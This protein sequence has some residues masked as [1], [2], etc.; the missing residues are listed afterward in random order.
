MKT[1]NFFE[2]HMTVFFAC[3]STI[4]GKTIIFYLIPLS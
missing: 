4:S 1:S 3:L 2:V